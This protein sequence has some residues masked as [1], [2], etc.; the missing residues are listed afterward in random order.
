MD[1]RHPSAREPSNQIWKDT[2]LISLTVQICIKWRVNY[3]LF[4]LCFISSLKLIGFLENFNPDTFQKMLGVF[5]NT[6]SAKKIFSDK[7]DSD[8]IE[9]FNSLLYSYSHQKFYTYIVIPEVK[10][11]INNVFK[12]IE[13]ENFVQKHRALSLNRDSYIEHIKSVLDLH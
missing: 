1:F 12:E 9:E 5:L 11:I 2:Q 13:I 8:K 4:L 3:Y 7:T 10:F 6:C